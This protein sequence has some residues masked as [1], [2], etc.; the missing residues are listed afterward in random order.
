VFRYGGEEFA[1]LCRGLAHL[2]AMEMAERLR[3]AVAGEVGGLHGRSVTV[4][5]GVA[6]SGFEDRDLRALLSEADQRLYEAKRLG[7]DRVVGEY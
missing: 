6:S 7:R 1:V 3:A 2:E 4:S 5:I